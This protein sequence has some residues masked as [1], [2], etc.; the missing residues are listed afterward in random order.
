MMETDSTRIGGP[1]AP[2]ERLLVALLARWVDGAQRHAVLTV[3]LTLIASIGFGSLATRTL[4]FNVDPNALF[5]ADL[6]FQRMIR[7]FE[8]YFPV[9]TD[10]LLVVIDG[11]TPE[12]TRDAQ[13]RLAA[14]LK[15]RT[16]VYT[17]VF[18]PGEE[19]FFEHNALL[20]LD[21]DELESFSDEM[22]RLQPVLGKLARDPSLPTL[23]EVIR[24]GLD[25]LEE[26][27][28]NAD[29]WA[30]VLDHMS[31]AT[32][33]LF[34]TRPTAISWENVL[35]EDS[36]I[37]PPTLRVIVLDPILDLERVLAAEKGIETIRETVE[38]LSL[39]PGSG[40]RVRT[41]GYPALNHEEML[42]LATDTALAGVISFALVVLV[43]GWAF[44]S[45][46]MV[47]ACALT[48]GVGMVWSAAF[49]GVT[50][51]V[52]N[53]LSITFG[54]LVIG[55][56]IDFMIHFG[57]QFAEAIRR[58]N[59]VPAA[60]QTAVQETGAALLLCGATT[61]VGF[62]AFVPTDYRGV[63][64]LGLLASGGILALLFHTLTL[65]PAL[66]RLFITP[67]AR[68]R[69]ANSDPGGPLHLPELRRPGWVGLTAAGLGLGALPLL[70]VV[71]LDTN[72]IRIRNPD[73]ESVQAFEELLGSR[74]ATPWYL[75]ALTPSLEA[76][77]QLADAVRDGP[78]ID[79]VVTLSDFVPEEQDDKVEL[80]DD[81]AMLLNLTSIEDLA[82]AN[83]AETLLALEELQRA[84]GSS[85]ADAPPG[86][87]L[88][89]S[90]D[91]L[92]KAIGALIESPQ[93]SAAKL[94][95]L[96]TVLLGTLP[97]QLTRLRDSLEAQPLTME[98]LPDGL[99][100]RM[101]TDD[102]HARVQIY[103][104]SDLWENSA[105]VAFVESIR[106]HWSDIT[107]LPV[108]LVESAE[109]TWQSLREAMLW[110]TLAITFMLL[111]LWRRVGDTLIAL[112]P[113]LAAV[114]LTQ[115]STLV[116]PVSFTFVN[117]M[118]L[119]LLLGIGIDGSVHLVHRAYRKGGSGDIRSATTTRAVWF[120][121]L[122]TIAS[123]GTLVISGHRG[124]ASLGF[125]L[126][127]GM[128][129]VLAANLIVLPA[130]LALREGSRKAAS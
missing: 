86:S 4:G 41:S 128:L 113:L 117:V 17:Q 96:Q 71:D 21:I 72:V 70:S 85:H 22:A 31:L 63:S 69:L 103:P 3:V 104:S 102:G 98:A 84:L 81:V 13:E 97:D 127:I 60:L 79:R 35:L 6:R 114:V 100:S 109:A 105:M 38:A 44:R 116:L 27:D 46:R 91:R 126:V 47:L 9:L 25:E 101:Q 80:L 30:S 5:S 14:A 40:I 51:S 8:R 10:S 50:V 58:G 24:L 111:V 59:D 106:P 130:L 28:E 32:E 87:P 99:V 45:A 115:V 64:D 68:E 112:G 75:D 78:G 36:G 89:H 61:T 83:E 88:A 76:A 39:G 7:E 62:L 1:A 95:E 82:P 26:D 73:T 122:T 93:R 18:L 119:P 55:L 53:P 56:G 33:T 66:L 110:A 29:R 43:M 108:N 48:L 65:L 49:A 77:N 12:A 118:V 57:M 2:E 16:D 123:F 11:D 15:A 20:Y 129:W 54:V 34:D 19:P 120:S 74:E 125:L 52:L 23:S 90:T 94:A 92:A 121:A 67:A 42:G 124:V 37:D 107:G